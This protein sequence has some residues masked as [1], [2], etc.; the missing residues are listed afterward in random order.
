MRILHSTFPIWAA[1]ETAAAGT[2]T[3]T[4]TSGP[5]EVW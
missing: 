3:F 2:G 5:I 4:I 1:T